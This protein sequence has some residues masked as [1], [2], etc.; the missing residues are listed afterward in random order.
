MAKITSST[1]IISV[2]TGLRMDGLLG[3]DL[4]DVEMEVLRQETVREI[5]NAT[6]N[7]REM[8]S[9]CRMWTSS[10]QTHTLLKVSLSCT[11]F[12]DDEAVIKMIFKERSPTLRHVSRTHRAALDWSFD[13]INLDPKIDIKY[14]DTKDQFADMST[15]GNLT[16]DE[17]NHLLHLLNV[18][19]FSM[20]SCIHFLSNTKQTVMTKRA[21]KTT[22]KEGS[23]VAKPGPMNLVSRS[24]LGAKKDPPQDLSYLDSPRSQE[25]NQ[26]CVSSRDKRLTRNIG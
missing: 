12:E 3:L 26:S 16:R 14:V 9:N 24:L 1:E 8:W 4:R 23:A 20:S 7:Q 13:R 17:W 11:S 2:D 25:L 15:K 19:N 5:T 21:Q 22:P 10:P 6:P 18:M